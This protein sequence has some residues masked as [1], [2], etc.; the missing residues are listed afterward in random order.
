MG[1]VYQT[2]YKEIK[3]VV[4]AVKGVE[5]MVSLKHYFSLLHRVLK[6]LN[7]ATHHEQYQHYLAELLKTYNLR[8]A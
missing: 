8:N 4:T 6:V 1:Q 2:V 7:I 3:G 5:V